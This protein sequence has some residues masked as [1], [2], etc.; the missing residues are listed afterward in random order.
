LDIFIK[1]WI[2]DRFKGIISPIRKEKD[3][4]IDILKVDQGYVEAF[5]INIQKWL[6]R[7]DV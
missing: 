7:I 6:A 5:L 4:I 2:N 1:D 3:M